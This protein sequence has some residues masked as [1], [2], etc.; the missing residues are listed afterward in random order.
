MAF[1]IWDIIKD[2]IPEKERSEIQTKLDMDGTEGIEHAL[3]LLDPGGPEPT[4][5]RYTVTEAIAK[6]FSEITPPIDCHRCFV[7]A[8]S[9]RSENFIP[10]FTL[11]Y[12]P[13]IE[14]ASDAERLVT[15]DGFHGFYTASFDPN[16][17][18]LVHSRY[19]NA[20]KGRILRGNSGIIHLYKLHGS[21]GWF[22]ING[23]PIRLGFNVQLE[24]P[25][26]RLMIPPQYRKAAETTT[27]PYSALWTRYRT[28]LVHGPKTLNRLVCIGYG[29]RDQHVNDVIVN[30]VC[31]NDFSLLIFARSLTDDVFQFWS[32]KENVMIVTNER[33]SL[34][35]DEGP[36]HID[37][38][39]F[40]AI[41]R[42]A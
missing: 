3:D 23:S 26:Q 21:M 28:W 19:Y 34:W 11:N 16:N 39:D 22:A 15:V 17:F 27:Q 30:A 25:G 29:M 35:G 13:L 6:Q 14:L 37:L 42:K 1:G 10:V 31:R 7:K 40:T 33:C 41:C 18:D 9:K 8:I 2:D 20:R 24:T 4:S 32:P 5:H 12:D 38:W 36:G